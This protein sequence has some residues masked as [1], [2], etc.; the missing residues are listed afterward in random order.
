MYDFSNVVDVAALEAQGIDQ[1]EY[2]DR[3]RQYR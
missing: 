3:A 2:L 1:V